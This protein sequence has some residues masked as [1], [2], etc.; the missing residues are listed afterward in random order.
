MMLELCEWTEAQDL[1]LSPPA[2]KNHDCTTIKTTS[3]CSEIHRLP[4]KHSSDSQTLLSLNP[5]Q[6]KI[7]NE[8]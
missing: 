1:F 3:V 8:Q 6:T 7:M 4:V 2:L 5:S